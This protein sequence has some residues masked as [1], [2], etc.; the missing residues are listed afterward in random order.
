MHSILGAR[1]EDGPFRSL[2][3]FCQRSAVPRPLLESL[4]LARAFEFTGQSVP[5]LLWT[6]SALPGGAVTDR[7]GRRKVQ[8]LD[9]AES[10]SLG[11][12]LPPLD[13][14]TE[15]GRVALDLR[16]LG[17]STGAHPFAPWRQ[18]LKRRGVVAST[19]LYRYRDGDRVRIA[20]I[21]VARARPPTR[22]GRTAIFVCLEDEKGLVDAAVFEDCYQRYGRAIVAS[23]VLLIEGRLSR[24][25]KLDLSVVAEKAEAL[26]R[27]D[28]LDFAVAGAE[29]QEGEPLFPTRN[30]G[31]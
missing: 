6:L 7:F 4:I 27:R 24:Q 17:L 21:V 29:E 30:W 19:D 10:E 16:L 15:W 1:R 2:R 18:E 26:P 23:P 31:Q 5:E 22:S 14:E 28:E 25:G 20:G 8:E 13:T 9:F 12:A 3:D 11:E